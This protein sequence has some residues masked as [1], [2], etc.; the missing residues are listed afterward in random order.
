[1]RL[2]FCFWVIFCLLA[3]TGCMTPS[4]NLNESLINSG[5]LLEKDYLKFLASA[6]I[7]SRG[8]IVLTNPTIN[9]IPN[10]SA[11]SLLDNPGSI[12][13]GSLTFFGSSNPSD[14]YISDRQNVP[15]CDIRASTKICKYDPPH[16]VYEATVTSDASKY[17]CVTTISD[18]VFFPQ[19]STECLLIRR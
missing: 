12:N 18:Y 10:N 3:N 16:V 4:S 15:G 9:Q 1:M 5:A 6:A 8:S 17:S 7:S 2:K 11:S 14:I 13:V 19:I